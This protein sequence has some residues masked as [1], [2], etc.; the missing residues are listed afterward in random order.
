MNA[1][2][3]TQKKFENFLVEKSGANIHCWLNTIKRLTVLSRTIA[4][5]NRYKWLWLLSFKVLYFVINFNNEE[6][7]MFF[8]NGEEVRNGFIRESECE[9]RD[10]VN[11]GVLFCMI[12]ERNGFIF[13]YIIEYIGE[14]CFVLVWRYEYRGIGILLIYIEGNIHCIPFE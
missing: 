8:F 14:S 9:G 10:E 6:Y 5:I 3:N 12:S 2:K 4:E 1:Y 13:E 7:I 11:G